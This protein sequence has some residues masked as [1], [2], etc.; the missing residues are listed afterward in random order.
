[1][2]LRYTARAVTV[3]QHAATNWHIIAYKL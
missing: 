2:P 1:M 3:M